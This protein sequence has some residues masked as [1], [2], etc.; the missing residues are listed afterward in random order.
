MVSKKHLPDGQDPSAEGPILETD[1]APLSLRGPTRVSFYI[2]GFN[3]YHAIDAMED[4]ALKWLDLRSL[5]E[6]YLQPHNALARIAFF[7]ALNTWNIGKRERHLDYVKALQARGVEVITGTFD[8]PRKF[9]Q[10]H[11]L[12]CR[13]Y[14][15]KKTDVAVAVNVLGDG[16]EDLYDIAFLMTAD[17]D[18]VPLA[19]RFARS[20]RHKRLFLITPP[21][22]LKEA[23]ELVEAIGTKSFQLTAGRIRQRQLPAELR[24]AKGKLIVARPALYGTHAKRD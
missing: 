23:R 15:E 7:T 10:T 14:G 22:R 24:D 17:S 11:E 5:C 18:H 19:E 8:R 12:W 9:C 20:L 1:S 4:D 2:D 3:L 16:F 6:S 21:D 13:N